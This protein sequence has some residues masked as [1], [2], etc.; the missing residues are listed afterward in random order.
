MVKTGLV[1]GEAPDCLVSV[2]KERDAQNEDTAQS[3]ARNSCVAGASNAQR[4]GARRQAAS[5]EVTERGP[6]LPVRRINE[7]ERPDKRCQKQVVRRG[8]WSIEA[9]GPLRGLTIAVRPVR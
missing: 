6:S 8:K 3:N 2:A 4:I 9:R 7:S 5:G 1:P